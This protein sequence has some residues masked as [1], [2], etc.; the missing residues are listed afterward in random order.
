MFVVQSAKG[1]GRV[2]LDSDMGHGMF[3][4][5]TCTHFWN[6]EQA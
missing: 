2:F 6:S 4:A 5:F 3:F 1:R